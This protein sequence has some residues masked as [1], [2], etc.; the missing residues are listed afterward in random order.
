MCIDSENPDLIAGYG[1]WYRPG[2]IAK[3]EG[4][5]DA[6]LDLA[7][8]TGKSTKDPEDP[9][10]KRLNLELQEEFNGLTEKMKNEIWGDDANYW[11]TYCCCMV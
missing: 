10:P 1:I 5:L 9:M 11:C 3:K 4:T 2:H 6:A 7:T 8:A